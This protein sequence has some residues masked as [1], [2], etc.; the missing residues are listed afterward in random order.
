VAAQRGHGIP[1]AP[2]TSAAGHRGMSRLPRK[3]NRAS[4]LRSGPQ[5]RPSTHILYVEARVWPFNG[6]TARNQTKPST[7]LYYPYDFGAHRRSGIT[8]GPP[9]RTT[10]DHEILPSTHARFATCRRRTHG[11]EP[12]KP[13]HSRTP[14]AGRMEW[15]A[16]QLGSGPQALRRSPSA[17]APAAQVVGERR[18]RPDV[19]ASLAERTAVTHSR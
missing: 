3:Q 8:N 10:S 13:E 2:H 7:P 16:R 17:S 14:L 4:A 15:A 18:E 11:G 5:H 6:Q 1:E 9:R 12:R 19:S